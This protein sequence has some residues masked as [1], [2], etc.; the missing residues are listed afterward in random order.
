MQPE[1]DYLKFGS[2][3]DLKTPSRMYLVGNGASL[4]KTNLDLLV[5]KPSM[6]VNKIHLIYPSTQWRPTHYV[7]IDYSPFD[8]DDWRDEVMP[9]INN[10]ELCLLWDAFRNGADKYDGN[11]EYIPDGIGDFENV[12][13]VPRCEHHYLRT[14]KWHSLCTG[15]NSIVSMVIWAV[16]LGYEEIVL[17]GCD[18]WFTTPQED[19]FIENYYKSADQDYQNRNNLN[20][21]MAHEFL[22]ANCPIPILDATVDGKLTQYRKVLLEDVC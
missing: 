7:K 15:L 11:F 10:G 3:S 20:I 13:Y 12:I 21:V 4:K 16:E 2:A 8:G 9:H 14:A 5:G 17:V 1:V 18:G 6:G 22:K 19:H